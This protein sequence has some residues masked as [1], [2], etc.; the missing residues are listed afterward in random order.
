MAITVIAAI[1]LW[2]THRD[3]DEVKQ[4]KNLEKQDKLTINKLFS[5]VLRELKERGQYKQK[6]RLPWYL[7][8]SHNTQADSAVLSQMGFKH[9]TIINIDNQLAVQIWLK[10]NAVMIAVNLSE[11]DHRVLHCTKLLLSKVKS[12]RP[13]QALNGILLSQSIDQLLKLD[14]SNNKQLANESRLVIDDTQKLCGQK[15]PLYVLFNQMANLADF[16]QFFSSLEESHLE[17]CFGALNNNSSHGKSFT[18]PWFNSAFDDL[19]HRMGQVVVFAIDNQLNE[20]FRRS[21]IAAPIQFRQVKN[22]ISIH[23]SEL[24]LSKTSSQEYQFRG[25][26]FTNTEKNSTV[27][28]PLTKQVAYQLD[29]DEMVIPDGMKM[30]QSLFI[31]ELF[32]GFI[33]P[34][35]GMAQVNKLRKRLHITFQVSYFVFILSILGIT[36]GLFKVN[37][38]YYQSLN[39]NTLIQLD[40]YKKNVQKSPY[41]SRDLA[42]N[43]NN[44][45]LLGDIYRH[46]KRPT[47]AYISEL[48]P[49]PSLFTALKKTYHTELLNVLIPSLVSDIETRLVSSQQSGNIVQTANFLS[50]A[51]SLQS[52]SSADWEKLKNYYKQVFEINSKVDKAWVDDLMVLMNDLYLLGIAKV[53]VNQKLVE[54]SELMLNTVNRSQVIFNYIKSLSQFSSVVDIKDELGTKF[55]QLYQVK[56][57]SMLHVPTIYT[58]QGYSALNLN[59]NSSL[60]KDMIT[61]NQ[62]LLGEQ[63]N[64]FEVNNL[65]YQLQRLYQRAYINYW[66]GF[67]DNLSLKPI[68][69]LGVSYSLNLLST[70]KDAPLSQLYDVIGYYTYPKLQSSAD[71][72]KKESSTDKKIDKKAALLL[73]NKLAAV[74]PTVGQRLMEKAIQEKFSVYHDFTKADENGISKL[75]NL[76]SHFSE[77]KKWLDKS[78]KSNQVDIEYFQ[79]LSSADKDQSLYLLSEIKAEIEQLDDYKGELINVI[80]KD[81]RQSVA[82]YLD[83][84]WQQQMSIPFSTLFAN[85]FPFNITSE[86]SVTLKEFNRYFKVEGIFNKYTTQLFAKFKQAE[87]QVF[88]NSFIPNE[89]IYVSS[90][91]LLQLARLAEIRQVLYREGQSQLSIPFKVNVKS[92][93]ANLLKF[94][95]FSQRTLMS[96][97][98]GPKLWQDFVWPDLSNQSELLAV[99]TDTQG[100]RN[101]ISYTGD[102]A[103]LQLIYQNYQSGPSKTEI[104]LGQENK[105][106]RLIL[107]V[108]SDENP[109]SPLFFSPLMLPKQLLKPQ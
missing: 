85:K 30:S 20:S 13:R 67:I 8:I 19:C 1:V 94:E 17:G 101:T 52:H 83:K 99:F 32:N 40:G 97:Q 64:E 102:W 24:L 28:D 47:P 77:V 105:D 76:V 92:M 98:H 100:Q 87:G 9:S 56:D 71:Q 34:E 46:Y 58:P 49:N 61:G 18:L 68:S 96:Y 90:E 55:F 41:Q 27:I 84:Q 78:N 43:V 53:E 14:K 106:I 37:F 91:T 38:E 80:N 79:Q 70:N 50:L 21:V 12:F 57:S 25:L 104:V 93:S 35:A 2:L 95:L 6:Y 44:L 54:N 29:H 65:V 15:L 36:A 59:V 23:L 7:F 22:D 82:S 11:H 3:D 103:W 42:G 5:S 51:K 66:L 69:K 45:R 4:R 74:M 107:R 31:A 75:S 63:L 48:I 10:N 86:S 73:D 16:C 108:E 109:L 39:A 88:L 72:L 89:A 33:R 62:S 26:F 60:I 81:I